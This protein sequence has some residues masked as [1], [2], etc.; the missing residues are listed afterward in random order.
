MI[1]STAYRQFVRKSAISSDP[2]HGRVRSLTV[3]LFHVFAASSSSWMILLMLLSVG[4][5]VGGSQGRPVDSRWLPLLKAKHNLWS[6][7]LLLLLQKKENKNRKQAFMA[8]WHSGKQ[9]GR[10]LLLIQEKDRVF[11]ETSDSVILFALIWYFIIWHVQCLKWISWRSKTRNM[12]RHG[13]H[14]S[15]LPLQQMNQSGFS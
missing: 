2:G 12:G 13:V 14:C 3:L 7:L 1:H 15:K 8:S 4:L 11:F 5:S 10:D 6:H 9:C